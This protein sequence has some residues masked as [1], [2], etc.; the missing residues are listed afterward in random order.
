MSSTQEL[1]TAKAKA[2]RRPLLI[3]GCCYVFLHRYAADAANTGTTA[4]T[5]SSG[6]PRLRLDKYAVCTIW[7]RGI[8]FSIKSHEIFQILKT[9]F[10]E[11]SLFFLLMLKSSIKM[12]ET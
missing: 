9:H 4:G 12:L 11:F 3:R 7:R 6:Q 2:K 8:K 10:V 5:S 1:D